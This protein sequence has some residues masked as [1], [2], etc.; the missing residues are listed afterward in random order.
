VLRSRGIDFLDNL[1]IEWRR[2]RRIEM[3]E[4]PA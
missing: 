2:L 4:N 3:L 1:A